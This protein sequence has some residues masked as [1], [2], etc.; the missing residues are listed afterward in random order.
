[1]HFVGLCLLAG[2]M[3]WT[4]LSPM[5]R[6]RSLHEFVPGC[7]AGTFFAIGGLRNGNDPDPWDAVDVYTVAN[8]SWSALD[9]EL[10]DGRF[11]F[12][13]AKLD[14]NIFVFGGLID[15]GAVF[16]VDDTVEFFN[17]DSRVWADHP[18]KLP[19]ALAGTSAVSVPAT[20]QLAAGVVI[21]GGWL[22]GGDISAQVFHFNGT[23]YLSLPPLSVGRGSASLLFV[24]SSLFSIGGTR[25]WSSPP[26]NVVESCD[27]ASGCH[28]QKDATPP[29][30]RSLAAA[31][32]LGSVGFV[33]GGL[34]GSQGGLSSVDVLNVS[35]G[36]VWT[37]GPALP[38]PRIASTVVVVDSVLYLCGGANSVS[39]KFDTSLLSLKVAF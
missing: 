39:S 6:P 8:D 23:A 24:G 18:L 3:A 21:A 34:D 16:T 25:E 20:K 17:C 1:M 30:A 2:A 35:R 7:D 11:S 10:R 14:R 27:W 28:W 19:V 4:P 36:T 5:P 32:S 13:S 29:A 38:A 15:G 9:S 12:A 31:V 26:V 22:D 33:I 37:K